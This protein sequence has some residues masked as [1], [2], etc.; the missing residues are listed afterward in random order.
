[1]RESSK[2]HDKAEVE[3][4]CYHNSH[5][6]DSVTQRLKASADR[7]RTVYSAT[8]QELADLDCLGR[9]DVLVDLAGYTNG[10][11]LGV[12]SQKTGSGAGHLDRVPKHYRVEHDGLSVR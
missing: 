2:A 7:W 12:H 9:I 10:N 1:M 6:E 5:E 3:V 4:T 8:D 11:R